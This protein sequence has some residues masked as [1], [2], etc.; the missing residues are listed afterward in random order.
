[1]QPPTCQASGRFHTLTLW[2]WQVEDHRLLPVGPARFGVEG[3]PEGHC[4]R[5]F[6]T[7]V[8]YFWKL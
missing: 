4:H 8:D 3:G 2:A 1:M 5:G 7:L 6:A